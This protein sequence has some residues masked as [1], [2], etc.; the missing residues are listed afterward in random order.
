MS[1]SHSSR[2]RRPSGGRRFGRRQRV[3]QFCAERTT[4]IDYKQVD[5]LKRFVSDS[6]KIHSRRVTGTCAKHQRMVAGAVKR[7]RQM[8]LLPFASDRLR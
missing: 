4:H 2:G 5:L 3:C 7:A 8:A 6:G 1:D